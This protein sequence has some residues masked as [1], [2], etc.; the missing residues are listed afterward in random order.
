MSA[1]GPVARFVRWFRY[2]CAAADNWMGGAW[3]GISAPF[4][5]SSSAM[6]KGIALTDVAVLGRDEDDD[7]EDGKD[8]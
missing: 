8:G 4:C 5:T 7:D 6:G 2:S 1:V 3:L